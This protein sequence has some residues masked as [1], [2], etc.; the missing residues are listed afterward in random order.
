MQNACLK[1]IEII[2]EITGECNNNCEYCGSKEISRL[3]TPDFGVINKIADKI[4]E[5]PP[6]QIDISGGDTLLIPHSTH[7]S[8]VKKFKEKGI[9]C[10]ILVNPKSLESLLSN[11]VDEKLKVLKLYDW[12]GVSIS[13]PEEL[14]LFKKINKVVFGNM[15]ALYKF[16][17][18]SN[19]NILNFHD[20][21]EIEEYIISL[22]KIN[23]WMV[24]F[25]MYEDENN[26]LAL[27]NKD[28]AVKGLK[29]KIKKSQEK[30]IKVVVSDN[31][32]NSACGAGKSS[33]G[34]LHD[35]SVV[36]CL[37]MRSWLKRAI[38]DKVQGNLLTPPD[39]SLGNIWKNS[40]KEY[41][42]ENFK[43]CKDVC[44]YK[45]LVPEKTICSSTKPKKELIIELEEAVKEFG[46]PIEIERSPR[47]SMPSDAIMVYGV[48]MGEENEWYKDFTYLKSPTPKD[49]IANN[50]DIVDENL[51]ITKRG[52][53]G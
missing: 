13:T 14:E 44:K 8:I 45:L 25:T 39:E 16:T 3:S 24:Q 29:E 50:C 12:I 37:S 34:I 7:A 20:Y 4:C 38:I 30:G 11:A 49:Y 5:F 46:K 52:E 42:F 33:L 23:P 40:F 35:G 10:K 15:F 43:C 17:I 27:Y 6:E 31:A 19:F 53:V 47:P 26:P 51:N 1:L 21:D 36:P 9:V 32:S 28:S 22:G 2:W 48:F 18:I 41:R